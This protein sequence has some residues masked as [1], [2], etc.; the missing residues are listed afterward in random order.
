M[1]R[2]TLF[3]FAMVL[4]GVFMLSAFADAVMIKN[5]SDQRLLIPFPGNKTLDL[6]PGATA[7]ITDAELATPPVQNLIRN[8]KIK[9]VSPQDKSSNRVMIKNVSGQR[10]L[11]PFPGNNR[12]DL[13]PGATASITN[14]ELSTPPVQNL[15]RNGKIKVVRPRPNLK[16]I[17]VPPP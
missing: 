4:V 1:I 3:C 9:V 14:S 12:L 7:D 10:L 8:G 5:M 2:K 6:V 11:I 13:A 15:I 17:K 16:P